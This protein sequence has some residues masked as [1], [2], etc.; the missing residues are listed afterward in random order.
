MD[1]KVEQTGAHSH[2]SSST[3]TTLSHKT[4]TVEK[5]YTILEVVFP[6]TDLS[7]AHAIL[8]RVIGYSTDV[9]V[10]TLFDVAF[11][12]SSYDDRETIFLRLVGQLCGERVGTYEEIEGLAKETL[13]SAASESVSQKKTREPLTETYHMKSC[14][15]QYE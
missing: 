4:I 13:L 12:A 15:C 1:I 9:M 5:A 7:K 14:Y 10:G 2:M 11:S 6:Y 8:R 3:M